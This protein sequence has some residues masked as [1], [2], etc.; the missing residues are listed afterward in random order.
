VEDWG[1][2]DAGWILGGRSLLGFL[3]REE[4]W[5]SMLDIL[6]DNGCDEAELVEGKV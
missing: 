1:L 6:E 2:V 3:E 4:R 5:V